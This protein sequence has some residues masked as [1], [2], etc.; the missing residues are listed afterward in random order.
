M[1]SV[2]HVTLDGG[3][4][5][6]LFQLAA[7]SH[8]ES[9]H[10][11]R[12]RFIEATPGLASRLEAYVGPLG[13]LQPSSPVVSSSATKRH[14][15]PKALDV[16]LVGDI[17]RR[18][19]SK[20]VGDFAPCNAPYG[21]RVRF[22]RGYFQHRDWYA[23]SMSYGL[24]RLEARRSEVVV[25]PIPN[26]ISIHLRRSDYVRLGWDLSLDYYLT[27]LKRL[28]VSDNDTLAVFSDDQMTRQLFQSVLKS[29]GLNVLD[30]SEQ[31]R[32]SAMSDFFNIASS[33]RIVM[34]NSTFSWWACKLASFRPDGT[35]ARVM[36]PDHWLPS[37]ESDLLIDPTWERISSTVT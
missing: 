20:W 15:L 24:S 19:S 30:F 23:D 25:D 31:D 18:L 4:G 2:L 12:V 26:L 5:N 37:R 32:G 13:K 3:I 36:C 27:A 34:S 22:L 1:V 9:A 16:G 6:L 28:G 33:T 11:Y 29:D 35:G 7:A 10:G 14:P 21:P 8:L 17:F